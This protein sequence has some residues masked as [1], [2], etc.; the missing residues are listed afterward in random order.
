MVYITVFMG[1]H[2][3][4]TCH[5]KCDHC[6]NPT[7]A[8]IHHIRPSLLSVEHY[9]NLFIYDDV[10]VTSLIVACCYRYEYVFSV[11]QWM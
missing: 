6:N 3:N 4:I 11:M 2:S 9:H 8:T 7:E 1:N 5:I 10:D